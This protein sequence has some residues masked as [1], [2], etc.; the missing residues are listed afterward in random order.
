[1]KLALAA[2]GDTTR[3]SSRPTGAKRWESKAC[4]EGRSRVRSK[5]N[6]NLNFAA[7]THHKEMGAPS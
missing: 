4:P 6:G 7:F 5:S 2:D 3:L 1:M